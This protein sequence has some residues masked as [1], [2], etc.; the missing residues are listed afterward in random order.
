MLNNHVGYRAMPVT[1]T[2]QY[3]NPVGYDDGITRTDPDPFVMRFRGQYWCYSTGESG[4]Q[5]S[6]SS[7]LVHWQH[8]GYA[9]QVSGARQYWAPCVVHVDGTFWMYVS[10]RPADSDDPH[11]ELLHVASSTSPAG[12]FTV[13]CRLFDTF[14]IDPHVVRDPRTGDFV[15]FY[16]TNDV[17]GL[18]PERAGT[19]IVVDRLVTMQTLAG[20]PRPVVVPTLEEEIFERNRFGDGRDWYT[21][22]AATYFTHHDTAFLTYSGNAYVRENY[23]IGY[24]SAPLAAGPEA[25]TWTK[26]P[27]DHV[28]APL[29]RRSA[30]VE[31]TGHN[32]IVRAP[33]LVDDWLVY[34]GRDQAE[35]LLTGVEQRVRRID[36][37]FYDGTCLTTPAP[38]AVPQDAPAAATIH[39]QFDGARLGADWTVVAGSGTPI[40]DESGT[41]LRTG[42]DALSLFVHDREVLHHVAEVWLRSEPT[43][44]GA[45]CG[46]VPVFHGPD[47]LTTIEL[48]AAT[49]S[50]TV[51]RV[52][53][54]IVTTLARWHTGRLD[55]AVW[56]RVEVER[57][58]DELDIRLDDVHAITV[59]TGDLEPGRFGL[60]SVGTVAQFS[61]V[62]L[63]EHLDLHG[64]RM[65]H[66]PGLMTADRHVELG[67]G[68]LSALSRRPVV[69]TTGRLTPDVISTHEVEVLS[70]AGSV[71]LYPVVID[72]DT[73]VRVR[74]EA[75]RV[76][77]TVA[78]AGE[79]KKIVEADHPGGRT[80]VRTLIRKDTVVLRAGYLSHH[81]PLDVSAGFTQRTEL[82]GST[83]H[84]FTL[85]SVATAAIDDPPK[86]E[87]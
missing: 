31:G 47:D 43:D 33:N 32:S 4:V 38:T 65:R 16:S 76:R 41:A 57:T 5:V 1:S 72:A 2:Q 42:C 49:R 40:R 11:D 25:L 58:F 81:L 83:L 17:T 78:R 73:Y 29:V 80:S 44:A 23:F 54:G 39:D 9:L 60:A 8:L 61:A 35:P 14:S 37:L 62:S 26:H 6:T 75:T 56:H 70:P 3:T 7:D 64:T 13:Q 27:S 28:W 22:E 67:D 51:C 30:A 53:H 79:E 74:L 85:T 12:P 82:A 18:E 50:L 84:G 15:L 87:D 19:S 66:L 86:E 48:D 24:S 10:F 55:L 36:P 59:T 71:D 77:I 69:L 20:D 52:R 68:G 46:V 34:H 63:T 21:I 45:R